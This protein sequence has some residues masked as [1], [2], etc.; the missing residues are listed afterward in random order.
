[1]LHSW[2]PNAA[3][4]R[5]AAPGRI[6]EVRPGEH[7][8]DRA[9]ILPKTRSPLIPILLLLVLSAFFPSS[10]DQ[11]APR[12]PNIIFILADDLGFTDIACNGSRYY[13]TPNIDRLASQGLR[14]NRHYHCPNCQP[15]R[16]AL[17]SGQ[18][19]PRTGVFQHFAGY[20]G[21]GNNTWRTTPVGT[22]HSGDWKLMEFYEDGHLELYNLREDIGETHNLATS[23][24]DRARELHAR[25]VAWRTQVGARMPTPHRAGA[26][27]ASPTQR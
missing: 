3:V 5:P 13:E 14:F 6:L 25:L 15:T 18:H 23:Q 4:D 7:R 24:P 9:L 8:L 27:P 22:I 19:G 12:R 2:I 17:L 26:K 1:M 21:S 16:A 11:P 20:L 10:A